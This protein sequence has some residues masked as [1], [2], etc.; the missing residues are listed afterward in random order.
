[1][2]IQLLLAKFLPVRLAWI[3]GAFVFARTLAARRRRTGGAPTDR[4]MNGW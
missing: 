1:M 2:L 4:R 3:V